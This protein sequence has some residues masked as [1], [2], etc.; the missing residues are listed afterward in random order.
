MCDPVTIATV[1][2][3]ATAGSAV[4]SGVAQRNQLRDNERAIGQQREQDRL[5]ARQA[6]LQS[7]ERMRTRVSSMRARLA[8]RGVDT[9]RGTAADLI[10]DTVAQGA[11]EAN[12][13]RANGVWRDQALTREQRIL[14]SQQ[15]TAMA[16]GIAR[17]GVSLLSAPPELW[18]GINGGAG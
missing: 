11:V 18:T 8:A 4:A 9:S 5:A 2:A 17:A 16:G 15:R 10:A 14:R 1:A 12:T 13:I 3:V 6:E 7:R